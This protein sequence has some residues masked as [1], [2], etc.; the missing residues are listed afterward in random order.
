LKTYDA[1]VIGSGITGGWAAKELCE[2]GLETLLLERGRMV[3]H[4]KDYKTADRHPWQIEHGGELTGEE[5]RKHHI[6]TRH[7]SIGGDNSH[8]YVDDRENPYTEVRRYDWIRTDVF[9]GRSLLWARMSLRWSDLDFEANARDGSA[10][11]WPIRYRDLAPWYEYV[12]RFIGI[13]GSREGI[14]HLP[15]SIFQAPMPL[16]CLESDFKTRIEKTFP[17][18]RVIP[19]RLANLTQ[20]LPGREPCQYRNLCRRGCPFGAYFSTQSS[21]YPVAM[22]TG[23]L[24]LRT[25]AL[26][27]RILYDADKGR[28]TG[29]EIIDTIEGRTYV[30]KARSIFLNASTLGSTHLLLNSK[31]PRFPNGMG[32]DSDQLGRNLMD[33]HKSGSVKGWTG[34]FGDRYYFGRRPGGLFIPRY[35][36]LQGQEKEYLRGFNCQSWAGREV[37]RSTSGI[38]AGWKSSLQEPGPWALSLSAFGECLPRPENRVTLN[39]DLT[40]KWGRPT[41]NIDCRFG[42]NE[43]KMRED[44]VVDMMEMLETAG[45]RDI[46]LT[47]EMSFPGNANHEMGTARMGNDPKSSVL[48][49]WNQ[50]H[51][52]PNVVVTDGSCMASSASVNPSLTYMALTVRAVDHAVREMRKGNI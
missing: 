52:V 38:G 43:R 21:T 35:V 4:V 45:M 16:N 11:D 1:I 5:R 37:D 46:R 6:Q 20:R 33:H 24:T 18:R 26:A 10:P 29:V 42:D 22:A 25:N 51:A 44:A 31:S 34:A 41:L 30:Y 49:G 19:P 36:N 40:D 12:E 14:P 17:G 47:G 7:Y 23:K 9:G 8:F 39:A 27:N 15:D 50:L 28:A 2:R 3:E 48:N 32:N 13:S